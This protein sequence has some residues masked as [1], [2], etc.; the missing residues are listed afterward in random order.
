MVKV[1]RRDDEKAKARPWMVCPECGSTDTEVYRSGPKCWG[2]RDGK[3]FRYRLQYRR[4]L[5]FKCRAR[6]KAVM[7]L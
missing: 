2:R 3:P 4:C 6:F 5:V 7:P 1:A